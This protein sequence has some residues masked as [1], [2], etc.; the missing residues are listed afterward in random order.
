M[1]C[2]SVNRGRCNTTCLSCS[3]AA[4]LSSFELF[5]LLGNDLLLWL[6]LIQ[7]KKI[8]YKKKKRLPSRAA[9]S[10]ACAHQLNYG[11]ADEVG[12]LWGLGGTSVCACVCLCDWIVTLC[13]WLDCRAARVFKCCPNNLEPKAWVLK[14]ANKNQVGHWWHYTVIRQILL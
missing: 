4:W 11:A 2:V 12:I 5:R 9:V 1:I 10:I 3:L 6:L 13:C 7:I 14:G 8:I